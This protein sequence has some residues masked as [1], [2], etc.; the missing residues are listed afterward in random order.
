MKYLIPAILTLAILF[1]G[2]ALS[3]HEEVELVEVVDGDTINV[4][5]DTIRFIGIDTP[6]IS[7]E[8]NPIEYDLENST[9]T[10]ECL[11]RYGEE[12]SQYV[13]NSTSEKVGLVDDIKSDDR[14]T[15]DRRLSYIQTEGD[16]NRK[17]LVKGLAQVYLSDFSRKN[18]FYFW[19]Y[20]A[21]K[22]DRGLWS[23]S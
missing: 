5:S 11:D 4:E 19:E 22:N 15:Y 7:S 2:Q 8:N 3:T 21:K 16:L 20:V 9:E 14:G 6:E 1:S 23:C 18:E 17:L 12:A 10:R 13:K